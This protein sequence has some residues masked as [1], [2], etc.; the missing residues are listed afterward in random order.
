MHGRPA[1]HH[2][3]L[4]ILV[5]AAGSLAGVCS[6]PA[7][8]FNLSGLWAVPMS[9]LPVMLGICEL[10]AFSTGVFTLEPLVSS[11]L[12]CFKMQLTRAD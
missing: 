5:V 3:V 1:W 10:A 8:C 6:A 7:I 11:L 9:R 4:L 2:W 12:I